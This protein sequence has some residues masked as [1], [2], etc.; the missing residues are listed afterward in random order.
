MFY[1]N[2]ISPTN[3]SN[4]FRYN[5]IAYLFKGKKL[6]KFSTNDYFRQCFNNKRITSLHAEIGCIKNEMV[7][8]GFKMVVIRFNKNGELC[9]SKPCNNCKMHLLSKGFT[10]IYCSMA[11]GKIS[12]IKLM[13]IEDYNSPSQ[14]KFNEIKRRRRNQKNLKNNLKSKIRH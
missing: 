13:D 2:I 4:N 12:K 6:V 9:D 3:N 1:D 7:K 8:K 5:H 10:T 11:N 14:I